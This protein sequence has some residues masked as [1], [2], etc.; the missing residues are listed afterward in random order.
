MTKY[1]NVKKL[2]FKMKN[3]VPD[4]RP[5]CEQILKEIHS[6]CALNKVSE[7]MIQNYNSYVYKLINNDEHRLETPE[8]E[9]GE[10]RLKKLRV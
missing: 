10:P 3:D 5:D 4:E 1:E 8:P 6:F 7:E 2:C 9:P